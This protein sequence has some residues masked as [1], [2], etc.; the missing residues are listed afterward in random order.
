MLYTFTN[1]NV[2]MKIYIAADHGGF[3]L[4]NHLLNFMGSENYEFEDLSSTELDRT[5]DYPDYAKKVCEAVLANPG[6]TGI[7]LCKS[8][9]GMVIAANKFKGIY[10]ALC[11]NEIHAEF[12]KRHNNANVLCLDSEY[13]CDIREFESIVLKFLETE[14]EDK[15]T[16]RHLRRFKKIQDI[17]QQ[18]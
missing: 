7:L 16:D 3:N 2:T 9:N 11:F 6:S 14:F 4:K 15:N 17:E 12:A 5:D 18:Q 10:A 13:H 1:Y 8:G